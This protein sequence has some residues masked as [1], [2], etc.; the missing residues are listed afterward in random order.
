MRW[1]IVAEGAIS[2]PDALRR[3]PTP[4]AA[5][6]PMEEREARANRF[7]SHLAAGTA[8]ARRSSTSNV[9]P[10]LPRR[11]ARLRREVEE[12]FLP[13]VLEGTW[14]HLLGDLP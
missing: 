4:A 13:T 10:L 1:P 14:R 8:N 2:S 3:S 11:A 5:A 12:Q 6:V 7:V 9:V